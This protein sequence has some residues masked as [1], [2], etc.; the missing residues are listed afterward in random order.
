[1][2]D[3]M[4][5]V[6]R[7][8]KQMEA[9]CRLPAIRRRF[10]LGVFSEGCSSKPSL[11]PLSDVPV[12]TRGQGRTLVYRVDSS[13]SANSEERYWLYNQVIRYRYWL[14][15]VYYYSRQPVGS[16][17]RPVKPG[18]AFPLWIDSCSTVQAMAPSKCLVSEGSNSLSRAYHIVQLHLQISL[19]DLVSCKRC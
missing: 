19:V 13:T 3:S 16:S 7:C 18:S 15:R 4:E 14:P 17:A 8:G 6:L 5:E 9:T 2:S 12:D 11:P 10:F 1:M